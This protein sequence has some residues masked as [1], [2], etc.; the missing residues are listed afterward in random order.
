MAASNSMNMDSD[1]IQTYDVTTGDLTGSTVTEYAVLCGDAN[2]GVQNVASLGSAGTVLTSNGNGALPSFQ[3]ASGTSLSFETDSGTVNP[4]LG[5]VNVLGG[6]NASTSGSGNTITINYSSSGSNS[7]VSIVEDF[8]GNFTG[9]GSSGSNVSQQTNVGGVSSDNPGTRTIR[10]RP[11]S[12]SA[13]YAFGARFYGSTTN[14][15]PII[16]GGGEVTVQF[17]AR[18]RDLSTAGDRV[19]FFLGLT[20]SE[21]TG[22]AFIVYDGCYFSYRDDLNSGQWQI[23]NTSSSVSTTN[24]TSATV[25]TDWHWFKIVVNEDATSVSY[26]ID[27]V[28]VSNSPIT[29]NIPSEAVGPT[30]AVY[31]TT[32]DVDDRYFDIDM[33]K[34]DITL[35]NSR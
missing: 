7:N 18:V 35:T 20:N 29:T 6:T 11:T 5:V 2:N 24:D 30:M 9:T 4:S 21:A 28:E 25:D 15:Q 19:R 3:A 33:L 10:T 31:R 12:F 27:D 17:Y 22:G 16:L 13:A 1:G 8:V 23:I 14:S 34:I 26:Y 32:S